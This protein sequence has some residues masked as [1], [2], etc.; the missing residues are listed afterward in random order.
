LDVDKP[1]GVFYLTDNSLQS[2]YDNSVSVFAVCMMTCLELAVR[3]KINSV[4]FFLPLII[5]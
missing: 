4:K 5:S 2:Q 1:M 3:C